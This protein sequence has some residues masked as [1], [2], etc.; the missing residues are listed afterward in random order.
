MVV[1]VAVV[2][3][4]AAATQPYV[5]YT[6]MYV[7][8]YIHILIRMGF[9]FFVYLIHSSFLADP[10]VKLGFLACRLAETHRCT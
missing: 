6:Y 8:I 4:E 9:H 1:P 3:E 10:E 7:Y 2:V 5:Q